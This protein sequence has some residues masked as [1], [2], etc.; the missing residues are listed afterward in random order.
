LKL[1]HLVPKS[2]LILDYFVRHAEGDAASFVAYRAGRNLPWRHLV[3]HSWFNSLVWWLHCLKRGVPAEQRAIHAAHLR[4]LQ[5]G[6][7]LAEAI[8]AENPVK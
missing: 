7:Q 2:R 6:R 1:T 5:K 8:E 3:K 4:G